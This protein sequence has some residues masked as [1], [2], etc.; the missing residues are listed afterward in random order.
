[1]PDAIDI[2]GGCSVGTWI[3]IGLL[4][5]GYVLRWWDSK[6]LWHMQQ[7]LEGRVGAIES[8]RHETLHPAVESIPPP[9]STPVSRRSRRP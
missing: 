7:R 3:I 8:D 2:A 1:M 9:P 4:V 5:V 6:A